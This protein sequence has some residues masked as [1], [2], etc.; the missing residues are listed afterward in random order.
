MLYHGG[1]LEVG[2]GVGVLEMTIYPALPTLRAS[3]AGVEACSVDVIA[4]A[5][6]EVR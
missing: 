5:S 3:L 2:V 6:D 4:I 1:G